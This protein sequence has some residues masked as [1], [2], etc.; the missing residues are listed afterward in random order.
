M[1]LARR[2]GFTLIELLVVIAIIAVLVAILLPAVQQAREAARRTQC[3]NNLKQFGIAFH[4][5]NETYGMFPGN[6]FRVGQ[7]DLGTEGTH[8]SW[9]WGAMI[10]PFVDQGA[11]YNKLEVGNKHLH[12]QVANATLLAAMQSPISIFRCPSDNAPDTNNQ[13]ML[14]NGTADN[15]DCT[16]ANCRALATANY[17]GANNSNQLKRW[18][19][20]GM[21]GWVNPSGSNDNMVL[22]R[23]MKDVLDGSSNVIAVG[24]RCWTLGIPSGGTLATR[25]GVIFGNNGNSDSH[26]RQGLVY[27]S[28]AGRYP[29]NCVA[30]EC[31]RGFSSRHVGGANF[32]MVDGA[33]RFI[34][35]NIDLKQDADASSLGATPQPSA[36]ADSTYERLI[37]VDDGGPV[38]DF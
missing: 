10:L 20:N 8:G 27:T 16:G 18:N 34:N 4:S 24:E 19:P 5:Y 22:R 13:L 21:F 17:V 7:D 32:V 30:T 11:L 2:R 33:V 3:Q 36:S 1:S 14:P 26:S 6:M 15:A 38:G 9:S 35:Q 12:Q 23:R 28:A 31:E 25:A 29:I 37:G